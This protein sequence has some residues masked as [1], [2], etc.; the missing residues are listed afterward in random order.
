[1]DLTGWRTINWSKTL[2]KNFKNIKVTVKTK[3]YERSTEETGE[4]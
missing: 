1:M 4:Q 2:R 3:D